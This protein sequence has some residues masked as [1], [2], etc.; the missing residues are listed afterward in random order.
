VRH[1]LILIAAAGLL[2]DGCRIAAKI[3][4]LVK[5]TPAAAP[6]STGLP[7][8]S[9][10]PGSEGTA[11]P[12]AEWPDAFEMNR[13]IGH[14]KNFGNALDAPSEGEWG[15]VLREEYF[16]AVKHAGFD[17]FRLPI[18]WNAHAPVDPPYTIFPGFFERVDWAVENA[19]SRGLVV[20]PDFHHFLD[21][22]NCASC[23]HD[24]LLA[25]WE[26]IADHYRDDPPNLLFERLNEPADA[27]PA[28]EWNQAL[29]PAPGV[30]RKSNPKRVAVVG[31]VDW[32]AL[33][34]LPSLELPGNDRHIIATFHYSD[35]FPFTHQGADWAA[36]SD[37][38]LGPKWTGSEEGQLAVRIDFL[39]A[40]EWG[41][42]HNRPLFLGEFGSYEKADMA[43]RALWTAFVAREAESR[44]FSWAY[45]EFCSSF[46]VYDPAAN[47]WRDPLLRALVPDPPLLN[48]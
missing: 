28:A 22:M 38:W 15:V 42:A 32:N 40:A 37:S 36:A 34:A 45:W 43:S 10:V 23:L 12:A 16:Q 47:R 30:I 6:T 21:Y 7:V 31:P 39:A 26:Q 11:I 8:R 27:V 13:R 3:P 17:S 4:A 48:G 46:G 9:P 25:L 33:Q 20:I 18:R 19:L 5:T 2:L 41:L 44:S 24:R 29:E 35:P 14:G 1:R